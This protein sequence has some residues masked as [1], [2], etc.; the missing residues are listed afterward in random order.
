M[1]ASQF[2]TQFN[3]STVKVISWY[4][5]TGCTCYLHRLISYFDSSTRVNMLQI[6]RVDF[7]RD[8]HIT[9][10]FNQ[11]WEAFVIC[12]QCE[13]EVNSWI[14]KTDI[15]LVCLPPLC[16]TVIWYQEF[17]SN[18]NNL[19]TIVWFQESLPN[20]NYMGSN[21]YFY[22]IIICLYNYMILSN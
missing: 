8:S 2:R 10:R 20:N 21:N 3:P 17:Q 13:R 22:F 6:V 14:G 5:S 4:S 16:Y 15:F 19:H 1:R 12:G 11:F 9:L 7:R 18:T